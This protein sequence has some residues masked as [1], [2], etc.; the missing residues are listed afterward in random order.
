MFPLLASVLKTTIFS[1]LLPVSLHTITNRGINSHTV[2]QP[3][4][5]M[6][7]IP[8]IASLFA[9]LQLPY[10]WS[11]VSVGKLLGEKNIL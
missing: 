2:P 5:Y 4:A 1:I 8:K 9:N 11:E 7:E 10:T 3:D 6:Y